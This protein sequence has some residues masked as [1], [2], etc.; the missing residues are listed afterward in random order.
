LKEEVQMISYSF[1]IFFSNADKDIEVSPNKKIP[2]TS[3]LGIMQKYTLMPGKMIQTCR[4]VVD[5]IHKKQILANSVKSAQDVLQKVNEQSVMEADRSGGMLILYD[6][7]KACFAYFWAYNQR[8]LKTGSLMMMPSVSEKSIGRI[9][10]E[11]KSNK[12]SR[13]AT[14][15]KYK[16]RTNDSKSLLHSQNSVLS[17]AESTKSF[18][19]KD[20]FE[21][22]LEDKFKEF[23]RSKNLTALNSL[24]SRIQ[25]IDDF[26][27]EIRDE[28]RNKFL[29]RMIDEK[30]FEEEMMKANLE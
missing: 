9:Q 22:V 29:T 23:L 18:H 16:P 8:D 28:L 4:K 5:F 21:Q 30:L 25:L 24:S 20:T 17:I 11:G 10:E 26:E 2:P 7:L 15:V 13:N 14:P 12:S 1:L 19:I 6:Y 3:S 27:R